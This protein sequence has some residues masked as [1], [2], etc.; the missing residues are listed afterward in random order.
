MERKGLTFS[1]G[2]WCRRQWHFLEIFHK[3]D[4]TRDL[5]YNVDCGDVANM[6]HIL[7]VKEYIL[8]VVDIA[9]GFYM[10]GSTYDDELFM[11]K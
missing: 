7:P 6:M 4:F 1:E 5:Y 3:K 11:F 2:I 10:V 8:L 9:Y